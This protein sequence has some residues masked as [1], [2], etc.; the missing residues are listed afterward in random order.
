MLMSLIEMLYGSCNYSLIASITEYFL[1]HDIIITLVVTLRQHSVH[2]YAWG[3]Q[4]SEIVL[5]CEH[6]LSVVPTKTLMFMVVASLAPVRDA[7]S[8]FCCWIRILIIFS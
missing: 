3:G 2:H 1:A 6:H 5:K 8:D 4:G 7:Y